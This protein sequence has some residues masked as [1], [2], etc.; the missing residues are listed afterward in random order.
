MAFDRAGA[1]GLG[2]G[3]LVDG[4]PDDA[5][6]PEKSGTEV[7]RT[8]TAVFA[9]YALTSALIIVVIAAV[10]WF[11]MDPAGRPMVVASATLAFLLQLVTFAIARLLQRTHNLMIGW[12]IGSLLRLVVLVL[13]AVVVARLFRAPIAPA[14]LSFAAFLFATTV[15]EPLF[16]KR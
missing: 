6:H 12:G 5:T 2:A 1:W 15:V 3:L 10:T 13:Y 14:L 4:A 7:V 16:L 9:A 8:G 11:L